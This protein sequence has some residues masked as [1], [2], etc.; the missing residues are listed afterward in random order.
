MEIKC[1]A[2]REVKVSA[3]ARTV[4]RLVE[5]MKPYCDRHGWD[6]AE[7]EQELASVKGQL[8]AQ[9]AAAKGSKACTIQ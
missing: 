9:E 4:E 5:R 3:F 1:W 8:H 7:K 2:A 6:W